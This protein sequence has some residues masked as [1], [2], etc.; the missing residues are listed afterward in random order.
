MFAGACD[1]AALR[2]LYESAYALLFPSRTEGFGLPPVEAMLCGC[3]AIVTPA[4]ALPE[5]CRDAVLYAD[6]DDPAGWRQAVTALADPVVR[7]AKRAAGHDRAA[8]FRWDSAGRQ[9]LNVIERIARD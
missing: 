3:P 9:L 5:V 7:S 1:D 8:A 2:A 6:V 4:G